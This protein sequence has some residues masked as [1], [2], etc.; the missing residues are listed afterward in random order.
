[1]FDYRQVQPITKDEYTQINEILPEIWDDLSPKAQ[2]LINN[3]GIAYEDYDGEL[4]T[5]I[6][7]GEECVFTSSM[8][9]EY[10]SVQLIMHIEKD[11]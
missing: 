8:K 10:V 7:N 4:V 6:I 3:Q 9:M 11:V 1:M 2:E 5:S